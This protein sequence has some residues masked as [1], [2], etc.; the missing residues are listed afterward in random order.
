MQV[1]DNPD[2]LYHWEQHRLK[3]QI[4][5]SSPNGPDK[6][7]IMSM[8]RQW[9][10][11][12][13]VLEVSKLHWDADDDWDMDDILYRDEVIFDLTNEQGLEELIGYLFQA[14]I[15]GYSI[16]YVSSDPNIGIYLQRTQCGNSNIDDEVLTAI[17]EVV[18]EG[19]FIQ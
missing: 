18:E 1:K 19:K 12:F 15:D 6:H 14:S 16:R 11:S 2:V 4:W 7:G 17:M 5:S 9:R 10:S 13:G 8:I 3:R